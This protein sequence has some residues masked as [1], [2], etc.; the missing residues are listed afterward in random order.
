[1]EGEKIIHY[2]K[3][4]PAEIVDLIAKRQ[5]YL[6][7]HRAQSASKNE[8]LK[9]ISVSRSTL[10]RGLRELAATGMLSNVSSEK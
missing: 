6:T 4:S 8:L 5:E 1:L 3:F 10:D 2:V 9:S 7:A